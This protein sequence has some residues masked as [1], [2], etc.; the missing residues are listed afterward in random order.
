MAAGESMELPSYI[1]KGLLRN[2]PV[3]GFFIRPT[4][5]SLFTFECQSLPL[6][7]LSVCLYLSLK[8]KRSTFAFHYSSAVALALFHLPTRMPPPPPPL[9]L[10]P[11]SSNFFLFL[12]LFFSSLCWFLFCRLKLK[13]PLCRFG[14]EN[15]NR[16]NIHDIK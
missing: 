1:L 5:L 14:E 10:T 12:H 8:K 2:P 4:L 7:T 9:F 6:F 11:L 15:S 13:G 3:C 16:L